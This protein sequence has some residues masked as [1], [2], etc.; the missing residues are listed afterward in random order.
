MA[1]GAW[2]SIIASIILMTAL[3]SRVQL[4]IVLILLILLVWFLPGKVIDRAESIFRFDELKGTVTYGDRYWMWLSAAQMIQDRP[5]FG[6]GY[7]IKIFQRLYPEY[8]DSRSSGFV[9]ESGETSA[10]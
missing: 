4:I 9:F 1:R 8:I 7:G 5:L 3:R 6:A 2:V 10:G